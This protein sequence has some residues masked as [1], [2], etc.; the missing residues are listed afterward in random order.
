MGLISK[1]GLVKSVQE[2][3][4][5]A[6]EKNLEVIYEVLN[7]Y[8]NYQVLTAATDLKLIQAVANSNLKLL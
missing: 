4:S 1:V 2:V 7:R 3:T 8:E 5:K 6:S